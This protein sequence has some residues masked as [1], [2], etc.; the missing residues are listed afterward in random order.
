MTL[1]SSNIA[2]LNKDPKF[3]Q[4]LQVQ[5]IAD[6]KSAKF[7]NTMFQAD[8]TNGSQVKLINEP[9]PF[10][11][12]TTGHD[13]IT[14]GTSGGYQETF[15]VTEG[16]RVNE[17]VFDTDGVQAAFNV[18][19]KYA[20]NGLR[21]INREMDKTAFSKLKSNSFVTLPT[22]DVSSGASEANG[23]LIYQGF[24]D[25]NAALDAQGFQTTMSDFGRRIT[26]MDPNVA[27]V[28]K[29]SS[30]FTL[31]TTEGDRRYTT[32]MINTL[33][34]VEI[35]STINL[36]AD[37]TSFDVTAKGA[38][39][40]G[41]VTFTVDN[42]GSG[43]IN[44]PKIGD[45]FTNNSK[46]YTILAVN[47][48]A[49]GVEYTV[50]VDRP[51]GATIADNATVSILGRHTIYLPVSQGMAGAG[52]VQQNPQFEE[53]RDIDFNATLVRSLPV[54]FDYF[55]PN[56]GKRRVVHVPVKYRAIA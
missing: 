46:T 11:E 2:N 19:Q 23:N 29:R 25:A 7:Y 43:T 53:L 39:A 6:N 27:A 4:D 35:D 38:V 54:M 10:V 15:T 52:V 44:A 47:E 42:G 16:L 51:I 31:A 8:L 28:F 20:Q 17:R 50:M 22:I 41:A 55:L 30:N 26:A 48:V 56:E 12:A 34:G 32:G 21:V 13:A 18:K 24:L 33:D 37:T 1:A 40:V 5:F 9:I 3:H 49:A 36:Y 14:Y 45:T